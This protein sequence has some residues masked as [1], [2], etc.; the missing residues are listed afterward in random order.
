MFKY[1]ICRKCGSIAAKSDNPEYAYQCYGCDS[2][3]YEYE[4]EEKA[5]ENILAPAAEG[6][7][8]DTGFIGLGYCGEFCSSCKNEIFNIPADRVSLCVHC[9]K[10]IF[11]CSAC[12]EDCYWNRETLDC[13]KFKHAET[14]K[15][16]YMKK[17]KFKQK[18]GVK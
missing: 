12:D 14:Y 8:K 17:L 1:R 3:L 4:T 16:E 6:T 5:A 11:P 18:A 2:D 15:K 10:E 9:G 7:K 13:H